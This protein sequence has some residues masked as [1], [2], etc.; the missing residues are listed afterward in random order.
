MFFQEPANTQ[1][2]FFNF[3]LKAEDVEEHILQQFSIAEEGTLYDPY[4]L[5]D[6]KQV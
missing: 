1:L 5:D 4:I 3:S 6:L 2:L